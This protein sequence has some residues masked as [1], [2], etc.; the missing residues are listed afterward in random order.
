MT[1]VT[2]EQAKRPSGAIHVTVMRSPDEHLDPPSVSERF[3][4]AA[5]ALF[6]GGWNRSHRLVALN[7]TM[8]AHDLLHRLRGGA[9]RLGDGPEGGSF[10]TSAK[11]RHHII[12]IDFGSLTRNLSNCTN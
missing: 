12:G 6:R 7:L 9:C 3:Y 2:I 1:E 10:F 11:N 5:L 8:P 4:S